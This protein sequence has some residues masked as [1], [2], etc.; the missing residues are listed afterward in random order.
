MS[1]AVTS[2]LE[3]VN[4]DVFERAKDRDICPEEECP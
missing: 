1:F 4:P 3:N 2:C